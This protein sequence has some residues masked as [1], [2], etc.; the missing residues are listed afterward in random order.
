MCV[1]KQK[2]SALCSMDA[3]DRKKKK[4]RNEQFWNVNLCYYFV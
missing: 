2:Y 1:K 4:K 3:S